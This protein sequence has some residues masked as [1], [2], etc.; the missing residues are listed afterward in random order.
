MGALA[1]QH[2]VHGD[3]CELPS[4]PVHLRLGLE[5]RNVDGVGA[6]EVVEIQ[7]RS[8]AVTPAFADCVI[9]RFERIL[10]DPP[11]GGST[12]TTSFSMRFIP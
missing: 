5:I 4:E 11:P 2:D 7:E 12:A 1:E 8:A 6:V 10:V 3:D 9:A